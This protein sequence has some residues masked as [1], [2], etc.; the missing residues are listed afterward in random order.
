VLGTVHVKDQLQI[1]VDRRATTPV[2]EVV[3]QPLF[4]PESETLRALLDE[5]RQRRRTFAV[6]VD[7]YGSTAGIVTLEDV[8]EALVGDI[9]DE[10]DRAGSASGRERRTNERIPGATTLARFAER[11]GT[12]L[13]EG[14]YET[15]AGLVMAELG[16]VPEVGDHIVQGGLELVVA[17]REGLRVVELLVRRS[18]SAS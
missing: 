9:E 2:E 15:V 1:P 11:F 6:V 5:F 4:V 12:E 14:E 8:L 10:F 18:R 13:P 16:R 7:E 3:A 17:R